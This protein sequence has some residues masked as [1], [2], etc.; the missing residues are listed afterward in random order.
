MLKDAEVPREGIVV[1]RQPS[2]TRRADGTYVR[3]RGG[4][5]EHRPQAQWHFRERSRG[6]AR[7]LAE[8]QKAPTIKL[9]P[10]ATSRKERS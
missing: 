2:M 8:S 5:G 6:Q 10:I 9:A 7:K 4:D 1:R 3:V